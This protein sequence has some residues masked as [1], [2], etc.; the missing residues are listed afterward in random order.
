MSFFDQLSLLFLILFRSP[1]DH[2]AHRH[3]YIETLGVMYLMKLRYRDSFG[4]KAGAAWRL[5][6]VYSLLPWMHKYRIQIVD[7]MGFLFEGL[8]T[9]T[10]GRMSILLSQRLLLSQEYLEDDPEASKHFRHETSATAASLVI[11]NAELKNQVELLVRKEKSLSATIRELQ[12]KTG[13][14]EKGKF[15]E[16]AEEIETGQESDVSEENANNSSGESK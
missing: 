5:L 13:E 6:F 9:T 7:D 8:A 2:V 15:V 14:K 12:S 3:P 10:R 1:L 11:E 16:T 4:S